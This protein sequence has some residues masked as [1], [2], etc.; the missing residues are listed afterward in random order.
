M[1]MSDKAVV[2]TWASLVPATH[3]GSH[4]ESH[5]LVLVHHVS[6]QLRGCCHRDALLVAKLVD[7]ALAGQQPLPET[8]VCS[9]SSHGTQQVGVDLNHLLHCLRGDVGA[10]CGPRV[11]RYND[12]MLELREA[13]AG[14]QHVSE[15]HYRRRG[16]CYNRAVT[17]GS[18]IHM[19]TLMTS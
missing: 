11:H 9:T 8:A 12:A 10:R 2:F 3:H 17:N 7:A 1:C 13:T 18:V 19:Y 5:A 4:A 16:A 14:R 6:K 15:A